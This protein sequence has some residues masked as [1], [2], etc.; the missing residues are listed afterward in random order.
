MKVSEYLWS[1]LDNLQPDY[2]VHLAQVLQQHGG[3]HELPRGLLVSILHKYVSKLLKFL[4]MQ[5]QRA[6]KQGQNH[7]RFVRILI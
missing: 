2:P 5:F 7:R 3:D 4:Q 1:H 6:E